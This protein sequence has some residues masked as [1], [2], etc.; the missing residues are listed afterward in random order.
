MVKEVLEGRGSVRKLMK[1]RKSEKVWKSMK[2]REA[3]E[4]FGRSRRY[5]MVEAS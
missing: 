3:Q 4:Q 2:V 5:G 1:R